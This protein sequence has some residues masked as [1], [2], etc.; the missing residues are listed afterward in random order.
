MMEGEKMGSHQKGF[1]E[2]EVSFSSQNVN[3]PFIWKDFWIFSFSSSPFFSCF[4]SWGLEGFDD[5]WGK[6]SLLQ[7]LLFNWLQYTAVVANSAMELCT[8]TWLNHDYGG[9]GIVDILVVDAYSGVDVCTK[10]FIGEAS[11]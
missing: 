7:E 11:N 10:L 5:I 2:V 3:F 8:P 6:K 4:D 1:F 9:G